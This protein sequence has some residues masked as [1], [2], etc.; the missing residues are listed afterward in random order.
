MDAD[1]NKETSRA[2][3]Q[4]A[5]SSSGSRRATLSGRSRRVNR[6]GGIPTE[7]M[8]CGLVLVGLLVACGVLYAM[9]SSEKTKID[10][11]KR[12]LQEIEETNIERATRAFRAAQS[13]GQAYVLGKA[14]GVTDED[15]FGPLRSDK[16]VYN[17]IYIRNWRDQRNRPQSEQKEMHKDRLTFKLS[18]NEENKD[19]VTLREG[20]AASEHV[21][22]ASRFYY[23]EKD[24]RASMGGEIK[25]IV[26]ALRK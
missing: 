17:V 11:A 25:V 15:L 12:H 19:G 23:P 5:S 7:L 1:P 24:D 4:T 14:T 2:P 8:V 3:A 6:A 9:R 26:Q 20:E 22:M 13:A 10:I 21:M 16:H 18:P